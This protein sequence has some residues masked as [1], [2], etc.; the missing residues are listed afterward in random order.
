MSRPSNE[1]PCGGVLGVC[2]FHPLPDEDVPPTE[3][4]TAPSGELKIPPEVLEDLTA[5]GFR[6]LGLDDPEVST[7]AIFVAP[8]GGYV[9]V[10]RRRA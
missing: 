6:L 2:P 5:K 3:R 10:P 9:S 4:A 8:D 7:D 1:C